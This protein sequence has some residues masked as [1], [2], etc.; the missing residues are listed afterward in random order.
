MTIQFMPKV[1][2]SHLGVHV[3]IVSF[4]LEP[5]DGDGVSAL[6]ACTLLVLFIRVNMYL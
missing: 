2:K 3:T 6:I 5:N 4:Y 1:L